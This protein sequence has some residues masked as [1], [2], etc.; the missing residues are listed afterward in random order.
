MPFDFLLMHLLGGLF[1]A[2]AVIS[3]LKAVSDVQQERQVPSTRETLNSVCFCEN[4]SPKAKDA[5]EVTCNECNPDSFE[6]NTKL[7]E[8][9]H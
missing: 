8:E 2:Q 6:N 9:K 7:C 5:V 1:F 3:S 4:G